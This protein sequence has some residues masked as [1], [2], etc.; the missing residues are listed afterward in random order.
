[1]GTIAVDLDD[2]SVRGE[3]VAAGDFSIVPGAKLQTGAH[4]TR[5]DWALI[6]LDRPINN[7]EPFKILY[8]GAAL[9]SSVPISVVGYTLS[10]NLLSVNAHENCGIRR[11]FPGTELSSGMLVADCAVRSGMSG[12]PLL[13]DMHGQLVTVGIVSERIEV[14]SKVAAIAVSTRSFAEKIGPVMR[15]SQVCAVGQPFC[16]SS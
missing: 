15:S 12:G 7:I 10:S 13:V 16:T 1:M 11:D 5:Q 2:R 9:P 3:V 8:S 6:E 14:G 4:E